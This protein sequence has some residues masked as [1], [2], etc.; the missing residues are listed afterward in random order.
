MTRS[1]SHSKVYNTHQRIDGWLCLGPGRPRL[2]PGTFGQTRHRQHTRQKCGRLLTNFFNLIYTAGNA[3][4]GRFCSCIFFDKRLSL[5]VTGV[6][7]NLG[8]IKNIFHQT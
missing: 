1:I 6:Y 4:L 5:G 2:K 8:S 3:I 7:I